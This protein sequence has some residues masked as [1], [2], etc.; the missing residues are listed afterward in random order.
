VIVD[1]G[2]FEPEGGE[3]GT[4]QANNNNAG[5]RE[6]QVLVEDQALFRVST[7]GLIPSWGR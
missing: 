1:R 5:G 6:E 2:L 4:G 7:E 3:N